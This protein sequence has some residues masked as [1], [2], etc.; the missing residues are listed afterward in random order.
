MLIVELKVSNFN[1]TVDDD[2]VTIYHTTFLNIS[3]YQ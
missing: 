1:D 3:Q 2:N